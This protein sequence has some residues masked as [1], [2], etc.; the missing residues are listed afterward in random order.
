MRLWNCRGDGISDDTACLRAAFAIPNLRVTDAGGTYNVGGSGGPIQFAVGTSFFGAGRQ[1]SVFQVT[2]GAS[3]VFKLSNY[4]NSMEHFQIQANTPQLPGSVYVELSGPE[5]FAA[6]WEITSDYTA[7]LLDGSVSKLFNGH[8]MSPAAGAIRIRVEG[9]DNSSFIDGLVI[10]ADTN[11]GPSV[12]IRVRNSSG[13]VIANTKVL[14]QNNCLVIDPYTST[15]SR[16]A[17]DAGDV[18]S[19]VVQDSDFDNCTN[20]VTIAPTGTGSVLRTR[21]ANSWTSSAVINGISVSNRGTGDVK[22][23]YL[24]EHQALFNLSGSGFA[25]LGGRT[26]DIQIQ[27]GGYGGNIDGLYFGGTVSS[28]SVHGA[29]Y[30]P[31]NGCARQ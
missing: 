26:S 11:S 30:R 20:G 8:M 13:A 31:G 1:K 5:S 18:F 22:G 16:K 15:R 23:I 25:I 17:T 7:F 4:H 14:A 10:G 6:D 19:L 28:I 21:F 3:R 9:G 24:V 12:G 27:G 2:S 29:V